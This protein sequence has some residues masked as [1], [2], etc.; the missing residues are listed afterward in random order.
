MRRGKQVY[1]KEK[2]QVG[3]GKERMEE[4]KRRYTRK[5]GWKRKVGED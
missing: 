4:A 2:R 1:R 5:R 3:R